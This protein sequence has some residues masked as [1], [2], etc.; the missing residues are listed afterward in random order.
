LCLQD[1]ICRQH[2]A[3]AREF[4]KAGQFLAAIQ[5]YEAAYREIQIPV[6]L[7]N[8]GRLHQ[9]LGNFEQARDY[10]LRYLSAAVNE[11]E[12]QRVRAREYLSQIPA[13]TIALAP[14]PPQEAKPAGEQSSLKPI[15]KKW[16]FWTTISSGVAVLA[17]VGIGIGIGLGSS[18]GTSPLQ[19]TFMLPDGVVVYRPTY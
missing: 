13:P 4:S 9:R 8:L 19:T 16:W 15:Y 11:N 17:V 1:E 7:Y 2:S 12:D 10:Y 18:A 6:F 14:M 3:R 5:E